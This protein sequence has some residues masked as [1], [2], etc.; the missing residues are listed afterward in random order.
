MRPVVIEMVK[1]KPV[2]I[3]CPKKVQVIFLEPKKRSLKKRVNT[4]AYQIKS[5][6]GIQ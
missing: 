3:S 1:G 5:F 6:L 2:V 4:L